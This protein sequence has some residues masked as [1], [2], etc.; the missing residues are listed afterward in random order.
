MAQY[1]REHDVSAKMAAL[2]APLNPDHVSAS[3]VEVD[4]DDGEGPLEI[5]YITA[6]GSEGR[7]ALVGLTDNEI[8]D[9]VM[10]AVGTRKEP[11]E[12]DIGRGARA[13]EWKAPFSHSDVVAQVDF[14]GGA[15][16][17]TRKLKPNPRRRR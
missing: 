17:F 3:L 2:L 4:E 7:S 16:A 11:M 1:F 8:I 9:A 5:L 13:R 6:S 10:S 15:G 14:A 12:V